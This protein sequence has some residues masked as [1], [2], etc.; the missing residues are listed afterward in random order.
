METL[1][2]RFVLILIGYV[3]VHQAQAA[4]ADMVVVKPLTDHV[5]TLLIAQEPVAFSSLTWRII[6]EWN[7]DNLGILLQNLQE[8]GTNL[9]SYPSKSE[10]RA[11]LQITD[12]LNSAQQ[13]YTNF[14]S[15]VLG[16]NTDSPPMME[17]LKTSNVSSTFKRKR[18]NLVDQAGSEVKTAWTGAAGYSLSNWFGLVST[19]Q[20]DNMHSLVDTLF[21]R[22]AKMVTIQKFQI[23][24]VKDLQSELDKQQLQIQKI[25]NTTATLYNLSVSLRHNNTN[26]ATMLLHS[27]LL[28]AI[29]MY[30]GT[31]ISYREIYRS[32]DRGFIDPDLI[33]ITV[34]QSTLEQI[35]S[36]IPSGFRLIFD[37]DAT[38]LFP[39]YN[40]KLASRLPNSR[41]LRGV[42]QVPLTG[43]NDDYFLYQS[44]PFPSRFGP[45]NP[46]RFI[47]QDSN[48][49]IALS[50]D[51]RKFMDLGTSFNPSTCVPGRPLV[52]PST[53]PIST[54]PTSNCVFHLIADPSSPLP[55]SSRC[56]V[57][58]VYDSETYLQS[59]DAENW[60]I[61]T[62]KSLMAYPTCLDLTHDRTPSVKFPGI[63]IEGDQTIY[64][65]RQ[66]SLS[67]G[68]QSIPT[69]LIITTDLGSQSG[70]LMV[71]R[72]TSS[73]LL[74]LHGAQ[75]LDEKLTKELNSALKDLLSLHLN[76]SLSNNSTSSDV[77][78]L[79]IQM[80]RESKELAQIQPTVEY[81]YFS[82]TLVFICLVCVAVIAIWI[83]RRPKERVVYRTDPGLIG[84][85][86]MPRIDAA[87]DT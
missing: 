72:L 15:L 10:N 36:K 79:L 6:F 41:Q 5:G 84:T 75:M 62:A 22:E 54:N 64:I 68:H 18:R 69:R 37:P 85:R 8:I 58:E 63:K 51:R 25:V 4:P 19:E 2:P 21:R 1:I 50:N 83:K 17:S 67:L 32:L 7:L 81:H 42:L 44:T 9:T 35:K 20:L 57:T 24:A 80:L 26:I 30:K 23:T 87:L 65:P 40:L 47:L 74:D 73:S 71:P 56:K 66:C 39:Y 77:R 49:F 53:V 3:T 29:G 59:L 61:S 78:K 34:L 60:V 27:D 12:S 48:R 43:L 28:A 55:S 52:C 82:W 46:R 11:L 70:R 86:L 38:S 45:N 13:D 16:N 31:V 76:A 14:R 33:P